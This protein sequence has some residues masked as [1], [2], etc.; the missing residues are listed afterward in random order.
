MKKEN[1]KKKHFMKPFLKKRIQKLKA[2]N[3]NKWL[4]E[5]GELE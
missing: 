2:I 4:K 1:R 3:T 5:N